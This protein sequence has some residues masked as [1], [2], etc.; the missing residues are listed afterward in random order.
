MPRGYAYH[1]SV[2]LEPD[3]IR[4]AVGYLLSLSKEIQRLEYQRLM[5]EVE[6]L[7]GILGNQGNFTICQKAE[8]L[9]Q[10]RAF[11]PFLFCG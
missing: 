8:I 4:V 10:K 3:K 1:G 7:D 5:L 2:L 6:P 11:R 9:Q